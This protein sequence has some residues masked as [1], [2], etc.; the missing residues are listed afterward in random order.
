MLGG[1]LFTFYQV[2]TYTYYFLKYPVILI[3]R[4]SVVSPPW[5]PCNIG[6]HFLCLLFRQGSNLDSNAKMWRLVADFMNDLGNVQLNLNSVTYC[7][8]Y[9]PPL[10]P[11]YGIIILM[12][13]WIVLFN[14]CSTWDVL[15]NWPYI[16]PWLYSEYL[17]LCLPGMKQSFTLI[18]L[19]VQE[20]WWIS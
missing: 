4:S 2:L 8:V 13:N 15:G 1:I 6:F 17:S 10:L 16:K 3:M 14:P 18:L 7:P 20:C 12:P 5:H 11:S 9:V 19:F